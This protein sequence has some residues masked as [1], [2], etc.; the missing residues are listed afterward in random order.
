MKR[1]TLIIAVIFIAAILLSACNQHVCPAYA[2]GQQTEQ[3]ENNS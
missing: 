1:L 3:V 2:K